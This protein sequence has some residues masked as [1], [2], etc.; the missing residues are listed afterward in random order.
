V[1]EKEDREELMLLFTDFHRCPVT[2]P[3]N[4]DAFLQHVTQCRPVS[5]SRHSTGI[6][7]TYLFVAHEQWSSLELSFLNFLGSDS[8]RVNIVL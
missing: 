5:S 8:R 1:S 4:S 2:S 7:R 6:F 3:S